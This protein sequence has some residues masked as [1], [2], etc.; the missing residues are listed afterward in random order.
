MVEIQTERRQLNMKRVTIILCSF[1]G[2]AFGITADWSGDSRA[3]EANQ[4]ALWEA[5][6]ENAKEKPPASR[7]PDLSLGLKNMGYR[8]SLDGHSSDVDAIYAK[9]QSELLGIPGHARYFQ[10]EIKRG[11]EKVKDCPTS[12]GE[13][14][15][16]DF[17]RAMWFETLKHLP[18][19]ETISV[20][21]EFLSD[22]IDT[23]D[24]RIEPDDCGPPPPA[25][26]F[27]SSY[28]ISTIGL[29]DPP[30][31]SNAYDADPEA[32]LARTRAWWEKIRTGARTFSFKGQSVEYRFRPDG[33]WE[34]LAMVNAPD[35]GPKGAGRVERPG[36]GKTEPGA[37]EIPRGWVWLVFPVI[38]AAV[39]GIWFV[40]RKFGKRL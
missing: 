8:R 20:L 25:N 6:L 17:D 40:S 10:Q 28:I 37:G 2:N 29:R 27:S 31:E 23:P 7:I 21:G 34:T 19:P 13:R 33:T 26:S 1:I 35:D 38:L 15:S 18:S 9:I 11:Q 30:A 36:V 14:V 16:Y 39:F 5:N 12:T 32:H 24:P 4:V 22:D 3:T